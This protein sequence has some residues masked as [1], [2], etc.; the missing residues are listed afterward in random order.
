MSN[1]SFETPILLLVFNRLETTKRVFSIIKEIKPTK[2]YISCDGPR[3]GNLN[4]QVQVSDVRNYL[5]KSINW[6]CEVNT[7]FLDSN[8]GC[9]NAVSNG[10]NWFFYHNEYGIVLEDDCLPSHSFFTFCEKMLIKYQFDNRIWHIGGVCNLLSTDFIESSSYY[11]SN[12]T[13]IWGWA[14]WSDR[15]KHYDKNITNYDLFKKANFINKITNSFF[16]KQLWKNAFYSS[17]FSLVNT[18]DFQWYYTVWS[19]NG[20]S[21][22]PKINLVS[23]IGFG[24]NSTHTKNPNHSLANKTSFEFDNLDFIE[25]LFIRVIE[26]YDRINENKLFKQ[27]FL[28]YLKNLIFYL[29]K[30]KMYDKKDK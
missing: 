14:T 16:I 12:Y 30:N 10:L 2:L 9:K 29:I 4:D 23:N 27:T 25:P 8:L 1:N 3:H 17:K 11:F 19:N 20:L 15:W 6:K 28:E 13:H 24:N 5:I 21:I 7:N 18:W 26:K 22:L